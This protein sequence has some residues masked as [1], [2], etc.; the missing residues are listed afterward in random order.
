M[1]QGNSCP[2]GQF[3]GHR[4][5]CLPYIGVRTRW[6][7]PEVGAAISRPPTPDYNR[8][9]RAAGSRPY[10]NTPLQVSGKGRRGRRPL[11]WKR[12]VFVCFQSS[13]RDTFMR[14]GAIHGETNSCPPGQFMPQGNSLAI[15]RDASPTLGCGAGGNIWKGGE[16]SIGAQV[17]FFTL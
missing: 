12:T 6:D 7:C 1:P 5:R 9:K 2:P 10:D 13:R 16:D 15:G 14:H 3:I 8:R 11:R 17:N 4:P